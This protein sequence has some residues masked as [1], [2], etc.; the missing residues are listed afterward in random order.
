MKNNNPLSIVVMLLLLIIFLILGGMLAK[1]IGIDVPGEFTPDNPGEGEDIFNWGDVPGTTSGN[2]KKGFQSEEEFKTYLADYAEGETMYYGATRAG[3]G[4]ADDMDGAVMLQMEE[5][6]KSVAPTANRVSGTNVQVLAIDEP[7][8]VKTDGTHIFYSDYFGGYYRGGIEPFVDVAFPEMKMIAPGYVNE[9]LTKVITA[10]PPQNLALAGEI[11]KGGEL[12]I[13]DDILVILGNDDITGFDV[14]SPDAPTR[15]WEQSLADRHY[16]VSSRLYE[17]T[18]YVVTARGINHQSPCDIRP[19][20]GL[21]I[22]CAEIYHPIAPTNVDITYTV[23]AL[24]AMT[25]EVED[26]VTFLGNSGMTN[27]YMSEDNIFA[28][29]TS[30]PKTFPIIADFF[31]DEMREVLPGDLV[32]RIERLAGYDISEQ[33]KMTEL[34]TILD[35]YKVGLSSDQALE[36]ENEIQNRGGSYFANH[37][38]ELSQKTGIMK[39]AVDDLEVVANI[40]IPGTMLNQFSLDE[41]EGNLRVATTI[42]AYI[43]WF[44]FD[45]RNEDLKSVSEVWVLGNNLQTLGHVGNL[46]TTE[47]IYSVRFLGERG[48]VVTFREIDPFYVIDLT[49]PRNPI[50]RGELKI[51]GYSS[52]LHPIDDNHI[53][54]IGREE[55]NVKISLFD[56]TNPGNP[57]EIS[58]Y[59]LR[60]Y[61]SEVL[62][63]HHAFLL[64]RDHEVFFLPGSNGAYIMSYAGNTLDLEKAVSEINPKRALYLDDYMYIVSQESIVV[65]DENNWERVEE[66]SL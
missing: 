8:I 35:S 63:N 15:A 38:R 23:I 44:G 53:L 12:F 42:E 46:G 32:S 33:A 25:G 17:D 56:V 28:T 52:Y 1:S 47:R 22:P 26:T 29:Y 30:Q 54:G 6:A 61:W 36:I 49:N 59:T 2:I 48:Y 66:L 45:F 64:D 13:A 24:D 16:V 18:I 27:V 39:I 60:E 11:E 7:D 9:G 55:S 5:S 21:T 43:P 58:K 10:F 20:A 40:E 51:P 31:T 41:Y 50:V 19:L 14:S 65:L 57:T 3:M 4:F 34:A 37:L 62:N